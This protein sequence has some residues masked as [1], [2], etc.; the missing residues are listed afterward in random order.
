[1]H[2]LEPY[3]N[4][5]HIYCS[6]EDPFSPFFNREY[7]EF[8]FTNRIYD[9]LIHPQWDYFGSNTL[10]VKL[11]YSDY[12][13]GVAFLEMIGEWN[14]CLYNDI[15]FLKRYVVEPLMLHGISK[16][17]LIGEN[18]LNFHYSDDSYYEEWFDEVNENDGWIVF[19]N[20]KAHVLE[21]FRISGIQQYFLNGESFEH[22][23]WRTKEP[24]ALSQLIN[25]MVQRKLRY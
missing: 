3:Y 5:R 15:M 2:T 10:Y 7:S 14:D 19:L 21:E 22:I 8:E 25:T 16:F 1:M 12:T 11:I 9:H 13:Q 6:E 4:W 20:F 18:V 23:E 17:V 24:Q